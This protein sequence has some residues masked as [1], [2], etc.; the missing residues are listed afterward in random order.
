MDEQ[1]FIH[2]YMGIL[3]RLEKFFEN[4]RGQEPHD[5]NI[6]IERMSGY[7]NAI[8]FVLAL[9]NPRYEFEILPS[10]GN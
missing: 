7:N 6:E 4:G 3:K 10:R 9:L 2:K 5:N 1:V 8:V